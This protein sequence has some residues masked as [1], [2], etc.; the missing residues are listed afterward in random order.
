MHSK[1]ATSPGKFVG[2]AV[3][4][5]IFATAG[6]GGGAR[7][8]T[9]T[10]PPPTPIEQS[11]HGAWIL[12]FHSD[13]SDGNMALE[14]NLSQAGSHVF[15]DKTSALVFEAS[16]NCTL[17]TQLDHL[18]GKCDSGGVGDVTVDA[19]LSS[20]GPTLVS[21]TLSETGALGSAVTTAS[22]STDGAGINDGTYSTPAACGFPEDHG[23][24]TGYRDS[25]TFFG[26]TYSG[27]FN[28]GADVIVADFSSTADSFGLILFGTDNGTSFALS[29][30][31][32]GTSLNLTG[33]IAG[34]EVNWFGL[35]DSTYNSFDIY[36]SDSTFV[37][38]LSDTS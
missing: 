3:T 9:Q 25:I 16:C 1:D 18:G 15:A 35:Y 26:E 31:T 36:D 11:M 32:V 27:S 5:V 8:T 24:F 29:G 34:R 28:G 13:V 20:R 14:A 10:P 2:M 22:A 4:A 12:L 37:G 33:T 21:L 30:S 23:T 7:M 6:C 38:S 17:L 19:T